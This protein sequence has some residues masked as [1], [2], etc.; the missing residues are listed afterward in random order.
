VDELDQLRHTYFQDCDELLGELESALM[1]LDNGRADGDTLND[2]FP[3]GNCAE[4][5]RICRRS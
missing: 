1:A 2:A 4:G 3:P 5:I